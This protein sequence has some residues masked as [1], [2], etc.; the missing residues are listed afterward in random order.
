MGLRE[1]ELSFTEFIEALLRVAWAVRSATQKKPD[2]PQEARGS[3][4]KSSSRTANPSSPPASS[5]SGAAGRSYSSIPTAT[6]EIDVEKLRGAVSAL[7]SALGSGWAGRT[8][9]WE[10][11]A[12]HSESVARTREAFRRAAMEVDGD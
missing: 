2:A 4:P 1:A 7:L 9:R 11:D 8:N 12:K 3:T 6:E 5:S 10:L